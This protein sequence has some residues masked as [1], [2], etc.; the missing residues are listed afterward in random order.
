M[1]CFFGYE[2][3]KLLIECSDNIM[4]AA[5]VRNVLYGCP[6]EVVDMVRIQPTCLG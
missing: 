6:D 2:K 5:I 4:F 1:S 3:I